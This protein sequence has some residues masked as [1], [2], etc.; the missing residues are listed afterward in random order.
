MIVMAEGHSEEEWKSKY[1]TK[2]GE[3]IIDTTQDGE[4][5]QNTTSGTSTTATPKKSN[6]RTAHGRKH[7]QH[8]A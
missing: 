2:W 5:S 1:P 7:S 6:P 3:T 8:P 4:K